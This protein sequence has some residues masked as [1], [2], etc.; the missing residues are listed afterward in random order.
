[1][2]I[3][4]N[5]KRESYGYVSYLSLWASAYWLKHASA[6]QRSLGRHCP[7]CGTSDLGLTASAPLLLWWE[8]SLYLGF[9]SS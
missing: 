2:N 8:F 7:A 9:K 5:Q 3:E 6:V 1:M 4:V